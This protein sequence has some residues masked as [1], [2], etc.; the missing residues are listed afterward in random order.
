M[1]MIR[2]EVEELDIE[3]STTDAA[4]VPSSAKEAIAFAVL[5]YQTWH[6]ETGNIPGATG[7][8]RAVILGK[9]SYA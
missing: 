3:V 4:G 6:R 1:E 7:A 5:A 9:V 8:E 2:K